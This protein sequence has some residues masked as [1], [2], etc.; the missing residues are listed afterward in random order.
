M[1]GFQSVTAATISG[2]FVFGLVLVLLESIQPLLAKRLNLAEGR[3]EWL[4]SAMN[5]TLI[6]MMFLSGLVI[7]KWDVEIVLIAGSLLTAG[8]VVSLAVSE[9]TSRMLVSVLLLG[10]GGACLSTSSS[11]LMLGAFYPERAAAS[12]NLGN[13]F[14]ALG[15]E[16]GYAS[17]A[18][19]G[20]G[21]Y[22]IVP[23]VLGMLA[24]G[25]RIA[26]NQIVG[27]VVLVIGLVTLGAV[28]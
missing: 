12:Q 4:L 6:P 3:V 14:F 23:A 18:A 16:S 27:I 15:V 13:V 26:P 2:A 28:S 17:L 21:M 7:D 1:I 24:L 19:T 9:T 20:T 10:A 5:L 11:V 8:A 22:P 25:E